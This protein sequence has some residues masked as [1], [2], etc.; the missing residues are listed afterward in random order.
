MVLWL[1][2][3]YAPVWIAKHYQ[4]N[5]QYERMLLLCNRGMLFIAGIKLH[6]T[7]QLSE[8]RPL[9]VVS[10]HISY[11]DIILLGSQMRVRFTPKSDIAK[12]PV[13]GKICVLCDAVF[14]DRS[15]GKVSSMKEH[16]HNALMEKKPIS[17]F[18][19]ATTGDGIHMIPFKSGFF[20]LAEGDFGEEGLTI[21]PVALTYTRIRKLPIDR[22]QWPDIAWYGDM[23]LLSHLYH[24]FSLAPLEAELVFLPPIHVTAQHN[25]KQ[26]AAECQGLIEGA[27]EEIR[28]R[29]PVVTKAISGPKDAV[30]LKIQQQ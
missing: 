27:I 14:I 4:K 15:P 18:P 13:I 16:L 7:G 1:A 5:D 28:S 25:R 23:E 24:V 22:T 12:W 10:N 9:L 6:V 3:W 21:Q 17:L 11:L 30:P 8:K 26:L 2:F 29:K 19:E 20:S